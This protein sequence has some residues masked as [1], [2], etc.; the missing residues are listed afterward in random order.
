MDDFGNLHSDMKITV[1]LE[2]PRILNLKTKLL[3][4]GP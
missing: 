3:L 4:S 2:L 1:A